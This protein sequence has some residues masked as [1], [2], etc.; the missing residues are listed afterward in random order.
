MEKKFCTTVEVLHN[1]WTQFPSTLDLEV[2]HHREVTPTQQ[3]LDENSSPSRFWLLFVV[4]VV[5][6]HL[7]LHT[8][9]TGSAPKTPQGLATLYTV[10]MSYSKETV[11]AL[12]SLMSLSA[13]ERKGP[14]LH[15]DLFETS[16]QAAIQRH[17]SDHPSSKVNALQ[18]FAVSR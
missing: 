16:G 8:M 4:V 17:N 6:S 7:Q 13:V 14:G 2:R 9:S 15:M 18:F 12:E 3:S 11:H 1:L 10:M 5:Y